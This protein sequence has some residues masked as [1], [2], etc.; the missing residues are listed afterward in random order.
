M[1]VEIGLAG[2][3]EEHLPYITLYLQSSSKIII[4]ADG[5]QC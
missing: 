5:G 2:G 3:G 1:S 4:N